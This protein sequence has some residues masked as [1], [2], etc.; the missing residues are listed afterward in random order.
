VEVNNEDGVGKV[1]GCS[2]EVKCLS[3]V[4]YVLGSISSTAEKKKN[5]TQVK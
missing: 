1:W 5:K 4:C 2:S 3:I